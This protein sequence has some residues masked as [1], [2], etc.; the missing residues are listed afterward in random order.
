VTAGRFM[1][2]FVIINYLTYIYEH[3]DISLDKKYLLFEK[4]IWYLITISQAALVSR[5]YFPYDCRN[6][7]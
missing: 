5:K 2:I 4:S 1:C 3:S 6:R 7:V